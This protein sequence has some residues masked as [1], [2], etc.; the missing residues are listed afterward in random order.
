MAATVVAVGVA[1]VV[2]LAAVYVRFLQ[3]ETGGLSLAAVAAIGV[4]L[5]DARIAVHATAGLDTTLF[6]ILLAANFLAAAALAE[7]PGLRTAAALAGAQFLSLLG[8]PDAA[9]YIAAQ[10]AVLLVAALAQRRRGDSGLLRWGVWAYAL[11]GV[12]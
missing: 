12:A 1:S 11:L 2:A 5:V 8:R 9:P 4:F 6:M 7:R 3:R 10:G